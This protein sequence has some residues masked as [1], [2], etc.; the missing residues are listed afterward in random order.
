MAYAE[1]TTVDGARLGGSVGAPISDAFGAAAAPVRMSASAATPETR[2][3]VAPEA[4]PAM[5][6][7]S[8]TP[9]TRP[10]PL[11]LRVVRVVRVAVH[12]VEALATTT[13]V[14]PLV[15]PE[16]RTALIRRW[17]GHLLRILAVEARVH[18]RHAQRLPDR[19]MLVANHIS[20]LDIFLLCA[21]QPARFVAKAEVRRWPLIG[22]LSKHAGTLF[23]DRERRHDTHKVNQRTADALAAG[24][25][26]AVFPEGTTSDGTELLRFHASLLQP[27]IDADGHVQ[28]VAIRYRTLAGQH[29]TAPAYAGDTTF[30]QSFWRLTGERA[31][32]AELHI[33]TPLAARGSH[34]R[35]LS[36]AAEEAIRTALGLAA[37]G[38]APGRH[39]G[40]RA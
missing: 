18:W 37:G 25:A 1:E 39:G 12:V 4:A 35:D 11:P 34:R 9:R 29:S 13:L 40:P 15:G 14:F 19:P 7:R 28:P 36:R 3:E 5:P 21:V 38:S 33:A 27:I 17:S 32:V 22:H 2:P 24:E 26:I 6:A 16:R 10:T 20:W 31:V 23:I 8:A 30:L